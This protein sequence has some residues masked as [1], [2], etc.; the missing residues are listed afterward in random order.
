MGLGVL[1]RYSCEK[2]KWVEGGGYYDGRY[3]TSFRAYSPIKS[4]ATWTDCDAQGTAPYDFAVM[5][6]GTPIPKSS[7]PVTYAP[8]RNAFAA[9]NKAYLYS[10]PAQT[11][12]GNVPYLSYKD[13]N[14]NY[15]LGFPGKLV[16]TPSH[17]APSGS[18][19]LP[20]AVLLYEQSDQASQWVSVC[21][22]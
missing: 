11:K 15:V 12:S 9:S 3:G 21:A 22:L 20:F 18:H 13:I 6:L 1:C 7:Y 19:V 8:S 16:V 10:Y 2:R 14:T 5:R 4:M 17:W